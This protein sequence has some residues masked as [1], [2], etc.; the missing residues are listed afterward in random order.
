MNIIL[1]FTIY[2]IIY[3]FFV[4]MLYTCV[5]FLG[6][7]QATIAAIAVLFTTISMRRF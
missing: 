7:E 1:D 6:F 4:L 5:Y 2:S 3:L